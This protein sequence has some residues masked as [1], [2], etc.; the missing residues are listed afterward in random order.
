M[1]MENVGMSKAELR[2]WHSRVRARK[3][4]LV[5]ICYLPPELSSGRLLEQP[6]YLGH[7]GSLKRVVISQGIKNPGP[8]TPYNVYA[9][10][11]TEM[12]A[13]LAVLALDGVRM[14]EYRLRASIGFTK[15]CMQFLR[16]EQCT[17]DSCLFVH[18]KRKGVDEIVQG[19][20]SRPALRT[21]EELHR[22]VRDLLEK[23]RLELMARLL[24]PETRSYFPNIWRI[25]TLINE[26]A[27]EIGLPPLRKLSSPAPVLTEW[28]KEDIQALV[29]DFIARQDAAERAERNSRLEIRVGMAPS[30]DEKATVKQPTN[31]KSGVDAPSSAN[32]EGKAAKESGLEFLLETGSVEIEEP[33]S[34]H[35]L[36]P[37][38]VEKVEGQIRCGKKLREHPLRCVNREAVVRSEID[39]LLLR[40]LDCC[41]HFLLQ[42]T[43][44]GFPFARHGEFWPLFCRWDPPGPTT[45]LISAFL[46]LRPTSTTA[47]AADSF[48]PF[49][50]SY[51]IPTE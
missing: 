15:Y 18:K 12:D 44:S 6:D 32:A 13:L 40:R 9:T 3:E 1:R 17:F 23:Y 4:E 47:A 28:E 21:K 42:Q 31:L 34:Q 51:I 45:P 37:E 22:V 2:E 7:Y 30:P 16:G 24:L 14:G 10:Y 5:Y 41:F 25:A 29:D 39:R 26:T 20:S 36:S 33:T 43:Q 27:C 49:D 38:F 48:R 11:M 19:E 46:G 35:D 8:R 50:Q